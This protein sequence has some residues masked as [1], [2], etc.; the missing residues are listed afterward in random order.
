MTICQ[1]GP[2]KRQ[3][4]LHWTYVGAGRRFTAQAPEADVNLPW[5]DYVSCRR[6]KQLASRRATYHYHGDAQVLVRMQAAGVATLSS[7][8][9]A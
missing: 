5:S 6:E 8:R 3:R 4:I 7:R 1:P 9:G 2:K